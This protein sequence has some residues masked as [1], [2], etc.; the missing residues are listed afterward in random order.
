MADSSQGRIVH[1]DGPLGTF[2]YNDKEFRIETLPESL[3]ADANGQKLSDLP[4]V[5]LRYIGGETGVA[6]MCENSMGLP[7]IDG[8][9][10]QIP[11]GI[12]NCDFM[13]ADTDIGSMPKIPDGVESCVGMCMNC[14]QLETAET[15]IPSSVVDIT[16]M[17]VDCNS[18]SRPPRTI[19]GN[20]K[21]A[22]Y[23]F[24]NCRNIASP[25][26]FG[27]GI[28]DVTGCFM[29]C[30]GMKRNP[31]FPKSVD[32]DIGATYDCSALDEAAV[33]REDEVFAKKR[34]KILKEYDRAVRSANGS[35]FF[36]GM[37]RGMSGVAQFGMMRKSGL[38][39]IR[40]MMLVHS[41]RKEG[42]LGRGFMDAVTATSMASRKP[43]RGGNNMM[44]QRAMYSSGQ[45]RIQKLKEIDR[46][47]SEKLQQLDRTY[48]L[49]AGVDVDKSY[50]TKA[51]QAAENGTFYAASTYDKNHLQIIKDKCS[52]G[53]NSIENAL[54]RELRRSAGN[55]EA[56]M[57]SFGMLNHS[58][59][60]SAAKAYMERLE[61][62][63]AYYGEAYHA[64]SDDTK[65]DER[66]QRKLQ[67]GL[68]KISET[69]VSA[70]IESAKKYKEMGLFNDGDLR[71][72]D[73]MLKSLPGNYNISEISNYPNSKER[74]GLG[75]REALRSHT[76]NSERASRFG[77]WGFGP[78]TEPGPDPDNGP[79][80]PRDGGGGPVVYTGRPMAISAPG[81]SA[82]HDKPGPQDI[83][84]DEP[85]DRSGSQ[86]ADAGEAGSKS[87]D[88]PSRKSDRSNIFGRIF[89]E[90]TGVRFVPA[91]FEDITDAADRQDQDHGDKDAGDE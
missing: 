28:K 66:T 6:P 56:G 40:S 8:S 57:S 49:G 83:D 53:Y 16:G 45:R 86:G 42:Q 87:N 33:A 27:D 38:G 44:L 29:S 17:F 26:A 31:K 54:E 71:K 84:H 4:V 59:R 19:P 85:N 50:R 62:I 60:N 80:G 91:S 24:T 81:V 7:V 73:R 79:E 22:A 20:V 61:G 64:I 75:M 78:N 35:G 18:M 37:A 89:G 32:A 76:I 47:Y 52:R 70:W 43:G 58:A 68:K 9:A 67:D 90:K 14:S 65:Y 74:A 82:G 23:A 48:G 30:S 13:F 34:E 1:Y 21:Y 46:V 51:Q 10:I 88:K 72:I 3:G 63:A 2:D 15:R 77:S 36:H 11:E 55:S 41:M 5:R 12:K 69:Q 39:P 25:P